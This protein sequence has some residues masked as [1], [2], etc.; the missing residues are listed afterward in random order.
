MSL[1]WETNA[2]HENAGAEPITKSEARTSQRV[3]MRCW[4]KLCCKTEAGVKTIRGH[5]LNMSASGVLVEALRPMAV[6]SEVRIHANK[7]L[8]GT[9]YVRRSKR[10]SWR[11]EIGLEFAAAVP[12]GH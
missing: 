9:A 10:R 11:F 2:P 3:P 4:A 7:L 8:A 6:G 12:Y 5:V 1:A